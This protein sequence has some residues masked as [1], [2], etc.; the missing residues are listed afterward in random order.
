VS[1][2]AEVFRNSVL[3]LILCVTPARCDAVPF[4]AN[5]SRTCRSNFGLFL[6][7]PL[8]TIV[9]VNPILYFPR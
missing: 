6:G 3:V 5:K 4:A 8:I 7:E 9:H 2:D 1:R